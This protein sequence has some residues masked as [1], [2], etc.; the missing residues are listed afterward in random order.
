MTMFRHSVTALGVI[1]AACVAAVSGASASTYGGAPIK[2]N[3]PAY[4]QAVESRYRALSSLEAK[5]NDSEDESHFQRKAQTASDGY[6]VVPDN[7]DDRKLGAADAAYA[8][9]I[10]EHILSAYALR[11]PVSEVPEMADL[12]VNFDCWMNDVEEGTN[13]NRANACRQR[14]NAVLNRLE[15]R[16][17]G[18]FVLADGVGGSDSTGANLG[19]IATKVASAMNSPAVAMPVGQ[20]LPVAYT[21][22][23]GFD[24]ANLDPDARATVDTAVR[25]TRNVT[26]ISVS[27]AGYT[28]SSGPDAYNRELAGKRAD[29][30][31]AA[32]TSQGV[33]AVRI[34]DVAH[35]EAR[36]AVHTADG[37]AEARNRRVVIQI[38]N[39]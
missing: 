2:S 39:R 30:V 7:P 19:A 15:Q 9:N 33:P 34:D 31:V 22:F 32:L 36:L 16:Y 29:A 17:P 12:T 18:K 6:M 24:S 3:Y 35:G 13:L 21:V 20:A 8:R 38:E 37:V 28:D 11:L 25:Q 5:E 10:Y 26:P 27:V 23:F 1:S 14:V 4:D